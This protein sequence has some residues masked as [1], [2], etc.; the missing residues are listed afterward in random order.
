MP[1]E[2]VQNTNLKVVTKEN[3][4]DPEIKPLYARD[5]KPILYLGSLYYRSRRRLGDYGT[6]FDWQYKE[7]K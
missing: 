6:D 2:R 1:K 3:M 4:E 7:P 5:L